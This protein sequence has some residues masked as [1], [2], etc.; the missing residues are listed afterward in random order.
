MPHSTSPIGKD[1]QD[2]G[3]ELPRIPLPRRSVNKV[4]RK[5]RAPRG[6]RLS[7]N[8]LVLH[9]SRP[10]DP[11]HAL[12]GP[13]RADDLFGAKPRP[14]ALHALPQGHDLIRW[15]S[16]TLQGRHYVVAHE[17]PPF[18]ASTL[19]IGAFVPTITKSRESASPTGAFPLGENA[20]FMER[21]DE[22]TKHSALS[23]DDSHLA[24]LL[25][26]PKRRSSQ[27]SSSTTF[28]E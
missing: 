12:A 3:Y 18:F 1:I 26:I 7:T 10:K 14:E 6:T 11:R 24:E 21:L 8:L 23:C 22:P 15:L 5:S 27:N 19:L 9:L 2:G 16:E 17:F 4:K 13:V 20:D 25:R 28:G